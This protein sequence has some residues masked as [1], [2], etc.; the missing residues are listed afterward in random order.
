MPPRKKPAPRKPASKKTVATRKPPAAKKPA[1]R[2]AKTRALAISDAVVREAPRPAMFANPFAVL[3]A[4]LAWSPARMLAT[5]QA[6]F[7][8]GFAGGSGAPPP[9][10]RKRASRRT[11]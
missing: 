9:A 10:Q 4:M 11:R 5:Q 8:E 2:R 7:W 3:E 6:A 1:R